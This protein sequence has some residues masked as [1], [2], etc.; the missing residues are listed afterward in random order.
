[1]FDDEY[2]N[3]NQTPNIAH[4]GF[5]S[6]ESRA[7]A[8]TIPVKHISDS[9]KSSSRST[10]TNAS[11]RLNLGRALGGT[12]MW[13][14]SSSAFQKFKRAFASFKAVTSPVET[15]KWT[16]ALTMPTRPTPHHVWRAFGSPNEEEDG[17][18]NHD[19]ELWRQDLYAADLCASL[20]RAPPST[21][22]KVGKKPSNGDAMCVEPNL[23]IVRKLKTPVL[24]VDAKRAPLRE[25][26]PNPRA[27]VNKLKRAQKLNVPS[28]RAPVPPKKRWQLNASATDPNAGP[29]VG[30][31][32]ATMM[33][34]S[35]AKPNIRATKQ[36]L[37]LKKTNS[38]KVSATVKPTKKKPSPIKKNSPLTSSPKKSFPRIRQLAARVCFL[39]SCTS[40]DHWRRGYDKDTLG[41]TL[42]DTC[43]KRES[44][45][46]SKKCRVSKRERSE[47]ALVSHANKRAKL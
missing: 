6:P 40:T 18:Q 38:F 14:A 5:V 47:T 24:T 34:P 29:N 19:D 32:P 36:S 41:E 15:V 7:C 26:K 22:R 30:L 28:P 37:S 16:P 17:K 20:L 1:M 46:L 10:V 23:K 45:R 8:S 39:C 31:R 43:G 44:R 21:V 12:T 9:L 3:E 35:L 42:C 2:A 27:K 13:N 11:E 4:D 25:P 33:Q